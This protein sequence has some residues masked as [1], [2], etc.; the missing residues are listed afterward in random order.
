MRV[1]VAVVERRLEPKSR[2][3]EPRHLRV[4]RTSQRPE[5][6]GIAEPLE[7]VRLALGVR[8]Q[9]NHPFSGEGQVEVAK[10][11]ESPQDDLIEVHY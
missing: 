5:E 6:H 4:G 11:P 7:E 8:T 3:P 2:A 9:Q 1:R 10:I